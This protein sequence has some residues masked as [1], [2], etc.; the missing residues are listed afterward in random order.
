MLD[1][2]LTMDQMED[3]SYLRNES[4]YKEILKVLDTEVDYVASC[5]ETFDNNLD[6]KLLPYWKALRKISFL[7]KM[8]PETIAEELRKYRQ[9]LIDS[10][11]E[12]ILLRRPTKDQLDYLRHFYEQKLKQTQQENNEGLV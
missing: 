9:A 5:M 4:S 2:G 12:D 8:Y 7:L 3:I 11:T 10:Q 6:V 1:N